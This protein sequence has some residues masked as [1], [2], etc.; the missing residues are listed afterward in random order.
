MDLYALPP[1]EFTAAR[2]A[3]AKADRSLKALRRPTVAA[4]VVNTLVRREP[5]LVEDLVALGA[6]LAQAQ[7]AGEG[8]QLRE[9]AG[10]RRA[11]VQELTATAVGLVGRPVGDAARAEV[12]ATLD[13]AL[14]DPAS[15]EAVR[16]GQ[17]VRA[18]AFAGFGGVDLQDAVARLPRPA[19]RQRRGDEPT[20]RS[21]G[22]VQQAE[23]A[24]L[25]AA[26]ALDDA[27]RAAD[28]A[29]RSRDRE[30]Q[31]LQDAVRAEAD[32]AAAVEGARAALEAAEDALEAARSRRT[33][34]ARAARSAER[35]S[36]GATREV[37]RAQAEADAARAA[38][39]ALRRG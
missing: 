1:E 13:A 18:L 33:E 34:R 28:A 12:A 24:A 25:E 32:A 31:A 16:S 9:L 7:Q 19:G 36:D 29:A 21:G 20:P 37:A 26:G 17:L 4:W 22:A 10:R 11:L 23:R 35:E 39:D 8:Q 3:A 15:A 14:A 5:A 27:V 30:Q 38:L 2:D 6:A